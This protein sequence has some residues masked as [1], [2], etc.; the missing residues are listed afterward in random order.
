M[1]LSTNADKKVDYPDRRGG[2]SPLALRRPPLTTS[3]S[4][5]SFG[6]SS[7]QSENGDA[8]DRVGPYPPNA[9][10]SPGSASVIIPAI[11]VQP[12]FAT[13]SRRSGRSA[14]QAISCLITIQVP[15]AGKREP[16]PAAGWLPEASRSPPPEVSDIRTP[17]RLH[18]SDTP[19]PSDRFAASTAADPFSHIL[20]DL[21]DRMTDYKSSGINKLGKIWL[22]DILKVRKGST[23]LDISVYLFQHALVCVTE[24][25]KKSIRGFLASPSYASLRNQA[26]D[27]KG[28]K[29][30]KG[31][32]KL[33]GRIYFKHVKRV[34]DTSISGELSLTIS[35]EDENVDSFILT[36]R[37]KNSLELWRKTIDKAVREAKGEVA[38]SK[39][40]IS[41]PISASP[42]TAGKL[43]KLGFGDSI[44]AGSQ[45]S[46]T[47]AT[48]DRFENTDLSG[49][50][51]GCENGETYGSTSPVPTGTMPLLPIHTPLDLLIVCSV[52]AASSTNSA[53]TLKIRLI[54]AAMAHACSMLGPYDRLSIV[55]Y[56]HGI[57][58]SVTR[59]P[60]LSPGRAEGRNKLQRYLAALGGNLGKDVQGGSDNDHFSVPSDAETKIDIVAGVNYG[61][62][63]ILQ[64]TTKNPLTSMILIHDNGEAVKRA[65]MDLILARAETA[66]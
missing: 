30:D 37:D 49:K 39:I 1:G 5:M 16:Y 8:D 17:Q 47:S 29:R 40:A 34:I 54:K 61:L 4:T 58:G 26:T 55:T 24:E 27:D 28:H 36:F 52:P 15:Q 56:Q 2:V 51:P 53:A 42:S 60:F 12:E 65:A 43:A 35:M 3:L 31:V 41:P 38:R 19:L 14:K 7:H 59:T 46:P 11:T 64:R 10:Q 25:K 32:L 22:F 63:R 18:P 33:K 45:K 50:T 20:A 48:L 21:K 13:I 9:V 57:G 23:V 6:S 66:K 44:I 62:D